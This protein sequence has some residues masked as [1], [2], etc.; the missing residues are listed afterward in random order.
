MDRET[1]MQYILDA[2]KSIWMVNR[3]LSFNDLCDDIKLCSSE[4]WHDGWIFNDKEF[5]ECINNYFSNRIK[6]KNAHKLP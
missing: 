1:Q 4:I 3:D 2:V 5:I 6:V